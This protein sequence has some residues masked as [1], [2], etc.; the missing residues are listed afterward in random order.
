MRNHISLD[1]TLSDPCCLLV[2]RIHM[3][4]Q[5]FQ[6]FSYRDFFLRTLIYMLKMQLLLFVHSGE[7]VCHR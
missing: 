1:C 3:L 6:S 5:T 7:H 4:R 2:N